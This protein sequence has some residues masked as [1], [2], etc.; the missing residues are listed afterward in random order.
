M[1]FMKKSL[2]LSTAAFLP[3]LALIK[4]YE[5]KSNWVLTR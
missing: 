3:F 4:I 2:F 5:K 1:F